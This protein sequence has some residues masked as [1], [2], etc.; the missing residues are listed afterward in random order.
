MNKLLKEVLATLFF[1]ILGLAFVGVL[2]AA[3]GTAS[4]YSFYP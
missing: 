2:L 1:F 3:V 4:A